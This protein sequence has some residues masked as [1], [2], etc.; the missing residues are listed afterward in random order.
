[1]SQPDR[2]SAAPLRHTPTFALFSGGHDSLTS[3]Y[4]AMT[5]GI[6]DAV[7]HVNTGIGIDETREFVRATCR[8]YGWPLFEI[9]P[10][11]SYDDLCLRRGWCRA[12]DGSGDRL[13]G[14]P[15][16]GMH[17]LAYRMLKERA[18]AAFAQRMKTRRGPDA[19][20]YVTGVRN[21]ES[22]VRMGTVERWKV[23][24]KKGW[25]WLAPNFDWTKADCNAL[26][27]RYGIAR[28]PVV[29][30]LHM[31]GE[32]LCGTFAS[33]GERSEIRLWYPD[34][35]RRISDLEARV[36]DAG[37]IACRW[38]KRPPNVHRYQ[39]SFDVGDDEQMLC[40]SCPTRLAA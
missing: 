6:A 18:L 7:V 13:Y 4:I 28:S 29:D 15:G 21:E 12:R 27:G 31:S 32:C 35:D 2:S 19:L 11:I 39:L 33:P 34:A 3:T 24:K 40:Q 30:T 37:H 26:I 36:R 5:Q 1:M 17:P 10:P 16:P 9:H 23:D 22:K 8:T 25:S 14:L 38:G 20:I